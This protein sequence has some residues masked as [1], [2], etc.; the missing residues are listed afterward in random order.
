M[1]KRGEIHALIIGSDK[2]ASYKIGIEQPFRH[3]EKAGICS[4]DVKSEDDVS[5]SK[6]ASAD[7]VIFFRTVK[8]E[9][10]KWLDIAHDMGKRTVYVID[11]HFIAMSPGSD[12]G[13][14][15]HEAS[16]KSTYVNFLKNAQMVK[17]ASKFFGKHI[18]MHFKP[19]KVV[20]FPGSVDF[21]IIDRVEKRK[22]HHDKIV[23]GY[24]G[25]RKQLAFEPVVKALRKVLRVY[26]DK[27][28]IEFFG[29][30][31]EELE[32][33]QQV[34]VRHHDSDYKSFLKRLYRSKWD[35]GLAPLEQTLLH[36]CKTNNKFREYAS[37]RIPGIYSA[38]PAYT[39][40]VKHKENGLLVSR[41]K[42]DWYESMAEL[43]ENPE[44][45]EKIMD[46]AEREARENFSV[47][48]CAD[49]WRTQILMPN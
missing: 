45:R 25:G 29:Y 16:R 9:A 23:I 43:I 24:E 10:Y 20:Y 3:L 47:A 32:G 31:P 37:C 8:K 18:E 19:R 11:D 26:G 27:I 28:R 48:A 2:I 1:G 34:H 35:I 5:V 46:K 42:D 36:D 4:Y 21:S 6:V 49:R 41:T 33:K 30:A 38:S 44:L 15:Y 17:V 14:Y 40:W 12:I 7:I 13:S 22:R 39:D